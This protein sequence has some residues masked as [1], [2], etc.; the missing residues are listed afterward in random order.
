MSDSQGWPPEDRRQGWGQQYPQ[1]R[2]WQPQQ[3]DPRTRQEHVQDGR[4]PQQEAPR[5]RYGPQEQWQQPPARA[6]QPQHRQDP[7]QQRPRERYRALLYAGIACTAGLL[8][9]GV[10]GYA[11]H[12]SATPAAAVGDGATASAPAARTTSAAAQPDT[13]AG[14][15][16]AAARFYA[17]YSASQWSAS[18]ASLAPSVRAKVTAATW[19]AVHAG[20][21][22]PSAGMAR[23]I[24]SVTMA[25]TTAVITE[26]IAGVAGAIGTA[27]DAWT[28]SG[29]RWGIELDADSMRDYSHGSAAAD[30]AAAK[31]AGDCAS[32]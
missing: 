31:T 12:G 26:T 2:P 30:I 3:Y 10:A 32:S 25:G 6:G 14:V 22:S 29:G 7:P 16:A 19:A 4:P 17:L 18:Y 11:L 23:V 28:Y 1:D 27:S 5:E 9:G 8:V 15:K 21:P 20:C 13:A 24:K